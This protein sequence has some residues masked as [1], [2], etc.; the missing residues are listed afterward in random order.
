MT[1]RVREEA[2]SVDRARI[3]GRERVHSE[4]EGWESHPRTSRLGV[5][6]LPGWPWLLLKSK[7]MISQRRVYQCSIW[8]Y[9]RRPAPASA[10]TPHL[11]L[12]I[13]WLLCRCRLSVSLHARLPLSRINKS[14][15]VATPTVRRLY[16]SGSVSSRALAFHKLNSPSYVLYEKTKDCPQIQ[17]QLLSCGPHA[18]LSNYTVIQLLSSWVVTSL[19]SIQSL[20]ACVSSRPRLGDQ[21]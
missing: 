17:T 15:G 3:G 2:A 9:L 16:P 8:S 10:L 18:G 11:L 5:A 13:A 4:C 19:S 21:V 1:L 7:S 20:G 6:V 12:Q 14:H